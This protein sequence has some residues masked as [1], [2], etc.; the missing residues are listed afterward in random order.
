MRINIPDRADIKFK[1]YGKSD[2][3]KRGKKRPLGELKLEM[4]V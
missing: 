2:L 4:L 1:T 3:G